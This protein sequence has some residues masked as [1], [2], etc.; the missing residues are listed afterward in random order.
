VNNV[1]LLIISSCTKKKQFS[2]ANQPNWDSLSAKESKTKYLK[3]FCSESCRA[4]DMYQGQQHKMIIEG[5]QILK[6]Y[7]D[8]DLF[9][10]SAGF[11]LLHQDEIIPCYESSF[12][13]KN[14]SQI[15][16][17]SNQ[18]EIMNDFIKLSNKNYDLIYLALGKKYLISIYDWEKYIKSLTIAFIPSKNNNVLSLKSNNDVVICLKSSGY[19]IHGTIG[20][21]GDLLKILAEKLLKSNN[22]SQT[23]YEIMKN[24]NSLKGFLN[25]QIYGFWQ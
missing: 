2:K 7:I 11:G 25:D 3:V 12:S 15:I 20:L 10:I 19:K 13:D 4:I 21:K 23:L 6:K 5:I 22:P 17:R 8:V 16:E 9:I 1:K 18:L 14:K 24:K